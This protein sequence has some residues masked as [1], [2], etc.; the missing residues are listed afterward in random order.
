MLSVTEAAK[1]KI[2][3]FFKGKKSRPIRL[4]LRPS[5]CGG[6]FLALKL[7]E[8]REG[9]EVLEADGLQFTADRDLIAEAQPVVIDF[10]GDRFKITSSISQGVPGC[11]SC[12]SSGCCC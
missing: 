2:S 4:Y 1:E 12:G 6:A 11:G 7:D 5:D 9:D 3:E 10:S 8:V